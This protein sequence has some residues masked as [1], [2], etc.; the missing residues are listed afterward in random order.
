MTRK[1][2]AY[3]LRWQP[4]KVVEAKLEKL[5]KAY[6]KFGLVVEAESKK[7]L[8]KGHGVLTGTL[9]RSIHTANP[10]YEWRRD[11]VKPS[12]ESPELG[13][14][15][16]Q[17]TVVKRRLTLSVGS[18]LVYALRVHRLYKYISLGLKRAKP[19]LHKILKDE[20]K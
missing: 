15:E 18:G 11:N 7:E 10:G 5:A 6:G 2:K 3:L 19:Q 12:G 20:F 8:R 16:T 1:S 17:A 13:G 4:E 14:Q 9:R